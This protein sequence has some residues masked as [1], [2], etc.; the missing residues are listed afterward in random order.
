MRKINTRQFIETAWVAALKNAS[1]EVLSKTGDK[2]SIRTHL[3]QYEKIKLLWFPTGE[4]NFDWQCVCTRPTQIR[5][6]RKMHESGLIKPFYPNCPTHISYF[7]MDSENILKK[8]TTF[9]ENKGIPYK[10]IMNGKYVG[11]EKPENFEEMQQEILRI[12]LE[13]FP[14]P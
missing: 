1:N 13:E 5:H 6:I 11:V 8:I 2:I 4:N 7:D 10:V 14:A 12:L 9:W 3:N